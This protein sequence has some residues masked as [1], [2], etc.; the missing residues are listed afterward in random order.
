M[1]TEQEIRARLNDILSEIEDMEKCPFHDEYDYDLL[2]E[3]YAERDVLR[4][5]LNNSK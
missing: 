1:K 4:W 3:L 2:T 5:V